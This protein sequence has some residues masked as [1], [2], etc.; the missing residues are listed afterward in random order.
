MCIQRE[1]SLAISIDFTIG[2]IAIISSHPID[3]IGLNI[4]EMLAID[5]C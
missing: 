5:S 1:F 3:E 2:A 4:R